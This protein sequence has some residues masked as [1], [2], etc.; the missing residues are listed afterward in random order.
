MRVADREGVTLFLARNVSQ[1]ITKGDEDMNRIE[2]IARAGEEF[3]SGYVGDVVAATD[4]LVDR[5]FSNVASR[6]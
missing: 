5:L 4:K 3:V 1:T 6:R 2:D